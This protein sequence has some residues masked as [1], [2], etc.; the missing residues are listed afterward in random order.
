MTA[1][2]SL[3]P[4]KAGGHRSCERFGNRAIVPSLHHRKE[5]WPSDLKRY[6]EASAFREAGVVFRLKNKKEN[7]P[8]CVCFGGFAKFS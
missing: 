1:G 7:H 2:F 8:D 3:I 4:R 5:G 6:R